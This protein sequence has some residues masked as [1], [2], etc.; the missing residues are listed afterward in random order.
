MK[1]F[2]S[3]SGDRSK[4][5][6]DVFKKWIPAV[7]QAA[8]PYFS[9][10]DIDKGSRWNQE[11]SKELESSQVGLICLVRENLDESWIMFEA[12]ALSKSLDKSRVCP[13]LFGVEPSD[14]KGPLV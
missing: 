5:I 4:A 13:M 9:P 11:I 12:G 10:S 7:I 6:A 14:I 1:I 8:K 3:W 2:I